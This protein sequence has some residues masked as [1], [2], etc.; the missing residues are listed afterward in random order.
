MRPVL[1]RSLLGSR[2][3]AHRKL[4]PPPEQEG[5][6]ALAVVD[7]LQIWAALTQC[8]QRHSGF[9]LR[10]FHPQADMNAQS[11]GQDLPALTLWVE[12]VRIRER[13]W[14]TVGRALVGEYLGVGGN[15][16]AADLHLSCSGAAQAE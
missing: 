1:P 11:E 12:D 3:A 7:Q 2:S 13:C 9:E 16:S 8:V 14:I 15:H 5:T 6:D 4:A 10:E